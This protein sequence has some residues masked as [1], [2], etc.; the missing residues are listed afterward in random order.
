MLILCTVQ[1]DSC[2]VICVVIV[3]VKVGK[4]LNTGISSLA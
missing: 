2:D 1:W 4:V 3:C